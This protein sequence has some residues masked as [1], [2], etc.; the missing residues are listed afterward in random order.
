M[1]NDGNPPKNNTCAHE[2]NSDGQYHE[3]DVTLGPYSFAKPLADTSVRS[4]RAAEDENE[5]SRI[6][7]AVFDASNCTE[8]TNNCIANPGYNDVQINNNKTNQIGYQQN[9]NSSTD[10]MR[11]D[12]Y[13]LAKPISN[14]GEMDPYTYNADYDHLRNVKN[15]EDNTV[16]VYDHV[17][18]IIDSDVTYDH[19]T[20][21]ICKSE[22]DNYDHFDVQY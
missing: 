22:S 10:E 12:D 11:S 17:P 21:N 13:C 7:S 6:V 20:I 16:K 2:R 5:Y 19:S 9:S 14:P 1:H 18:N 3:S 15:R 4:E 8:K